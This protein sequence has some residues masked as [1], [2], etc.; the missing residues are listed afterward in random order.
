MG[1]FLAEKWERL[2]TSVRMIVEV[3]CARKSVVLRTDST[4]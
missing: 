3:V 2:W 1:L 4:S